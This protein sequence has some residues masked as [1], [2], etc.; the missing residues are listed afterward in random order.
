MALKLLNLAGGDCMVD[1]DRLEA[2]EGFCRVS[3]RVEHHGLPRRERRILERRW[4]KQQSRSFPSPSAVFRY[5]AAFHDPA[6]EKQRQPH[7]AFIPASNE[8]LRTLGRVNRDFVA[9]VQSRSPKSQASLDMD[10]TLVSSQKE[11]AQ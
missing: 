4:R 8:H 6:Q 5:L 9:F 3:Q 11:K 7:T 10:A 1:I 2:D